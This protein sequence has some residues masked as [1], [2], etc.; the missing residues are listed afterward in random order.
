MAT[1]FSKGQLVTVIGTWDQKG[2]AFYRHAIVYSCGYKRMILTDAT[3][4]EETGSWRNPKV[5]DVKDAAGN[6]G[7]WHGVF[8]RMSDAEAEALCIEAATL[9]LVAY[10]AHY[11]HRIQ[12][13]ASDPKFVQVMLKHKAELHEPR[14]IKR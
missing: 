3:T 7:H 10:N 8:P 2:T 9:M 11:E 4:G 5:G 13:Y 6:G 1:A 12:Q 14:F